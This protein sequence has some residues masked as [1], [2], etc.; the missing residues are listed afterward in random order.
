MRFSTQVHAV[1]IDLL[2]VAEHG[3]LVL[4]AEGLAAFGEPV[5]VD[6]GLS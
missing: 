2:V 3:G 5:A 1:L 6:V 4:A